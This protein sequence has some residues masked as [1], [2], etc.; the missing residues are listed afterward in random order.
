MPHG[1]TAQGGVR[2]A[3]EP[4]TIKSIRLQTSKG[5]HICPHSFI[6]RANLKILN[7]SNYSS[8]K[9]CFT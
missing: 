3:F 6:G 2:V 1:L 8:R 5:R 9:A 7:L 4:T